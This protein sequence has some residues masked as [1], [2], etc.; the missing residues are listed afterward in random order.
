[1]SIPMILGATTRSFATTISAKRL[2][3]SAS[4]REESCCTNRPGLH[5]RHVKIKSTEP[6]PRTDKTAYKDI[7]VQIDSVLW[8]APVGHLLTIHGVEYEVR[9]QVA[10]KERGRKKMLAQMKADAA[11]R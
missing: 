9:G 10:E 7:P 5:P 3:L 11:A 2:V 1:M 4:P 6:H 8:N